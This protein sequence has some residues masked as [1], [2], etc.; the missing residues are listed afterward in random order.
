MNSVTKMLMGFLIAILGVYWYIAGSVFGWR[1][2]GLTPAQTLGIVFVGL[3]G[4]FLI[5][6]GLLIAWIEYEDI[7]WEMKEKHM[8]KKINKK[9]K[10]KKRKK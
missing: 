7:K 4:I 2:A 10:R 5:M 6:L 9:P 1:P 3:F 8:V